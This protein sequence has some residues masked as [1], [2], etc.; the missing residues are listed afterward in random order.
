MS[1]RNYSALLSL[2]ECQTI[3]LKYQQESALDTQLKVQSYEILSATDAKGFLG[4]YFH[5]FIKC[6]PTNEALEV[7]I[8]FN[9][10]KTNRT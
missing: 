4:E 2:D 7:H 6:Y 1:H 8:F 5:L 3:I 10:K 9:V